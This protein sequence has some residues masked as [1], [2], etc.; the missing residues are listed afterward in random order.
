MD[1]ILALL[2]AVAPSPT[3]GFCVRPKVRLT[4]PSHGVTW[5]RHPTQQYSVRASRTS[6]SLTALD[7]CISTSITTTPSPPQSLLLSSNGNDSALGWIGLPALVL[8][9]AVAAFVYANVTY[10]SEIRQASDELRW[11]QRQDEISKIITMV[12][13]NKDVA[14][15]RRPLEAALGMTLEQYLE[16]RRQQQNNSEPQSQ[17]SPADDRLVTMIEGLLQSNDKK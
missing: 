17:S 8:L 11:Q 15:L 10:T 5:Y 2:L 7:D 13:P 3:Y 14:E 1:W 4:S 16:Q 9:L 6:L 12:G